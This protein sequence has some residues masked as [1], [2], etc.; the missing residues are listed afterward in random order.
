MKVLIVGAG[1]REH[2][3]ALAVAKSKKVDQ[4]YCAPGNA[5]VESIAK[6]VPIS[7]M[8]FDRLTEFALSNEIDFTIIGPDD[9]LVAGIVD[10]FEEICGGKLDTVLS[11]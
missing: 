2:A 3:I 7:V 4:I 11:K 9:P 10:A 8:E 6:C 1:G 5:G